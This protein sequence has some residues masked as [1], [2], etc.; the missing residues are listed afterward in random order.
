[1]NIL[2]D[3]SSVTKNKAGAGI[4]AINLIDE[5]TLIHPG[6]RFFVLAQDD[7]PELDFGTR[8]NVTMI[9]VP[10]KLF[11]RLPIRFLLEQTLL[12]LL[13]LKHRIDLVHS[14]HY[15]FP[16]LRFG[17][18]QVVTLHDMTSFSMPEV[19]RS[20]LHRFYYRGFI[21]ASVR[22]A[23][24]VIFVS[25]STLQDCI[26]RFGLRGPASV[27]H[28]GKSQAFHPGLDSAEVQRLRDK[29]GL[30]GDFILYVGTI[31]PRK[32]LSRL[33]S[34]FASVS[35]AFPGLK[36]AIIGMK[37][38]MYGDLME[39]IHAFNLES[40][41]V[42]TGFIPEAEKPFLFAGARV[43]AYPSLYEGFGIPV[44]EALACGIPTLTSNVSSL[45]EVAGD[46]A[47]LVDPMNVQDISLGLK[48]LLSD[49]SLRDRLR[50][51]SLAQAARF[52]WAK[53]AAETLR[54]YEDVL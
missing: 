18:R 17:T 43:F 15:S 26:A 42:F 35:V 54:A 5:L 40:R 24:K 4:Y 16:L 13:L 37:G 14:L 11:R 3:A 27:I 52:T 12:P 45:P 41:I 31:E 10:A 9:R 6:P 23:D 28:L 2:I 8:G 25:H 7:D 50:A 33:V 30:Q 1:M 32:N 44:L 38:W 47:I 51:L 53:T 34:A 46:A 20:L 22:F 19:H 48:R 29:Y 49:E 36:L 21:R 39:T